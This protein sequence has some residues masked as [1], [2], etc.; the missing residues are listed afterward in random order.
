MQEAQNVNANPIV[1]TLPP[2]IKRV[3]AVNAV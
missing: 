2:L 1:N 3:K